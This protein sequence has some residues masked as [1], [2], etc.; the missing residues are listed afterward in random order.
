[1][2]RVL[3]QVHGGSAAFA[4][5]FVDGVAS[6]GS[7]DQLISGHVAKLIETVGTGQGIN[8]SC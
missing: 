7:A 2:I 1:M 8:D 3:G 6:Y 4:D 5:F